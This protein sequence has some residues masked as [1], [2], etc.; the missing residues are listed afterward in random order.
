MW[1]HKHHAFTS[2]KF[3]F[4]FWPVLLWQRFLILDHVPTINSF[5]SNSAWTV[6]LL[7]ASFNFLLITCCIILYYFALLFSLLFVFVI[8]LYYIIRILYMTTTKPTNDVLRV[9]LLHQLCWYII[10]VTY[11]QI[12]L[13][14]MLIN[15]KQFSIQLSD[16]L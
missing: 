6:S 16:N 12:F 7:I 14:I 8:L 9:F 15:Q 2:N 3:L 11:T 10:V 4:K 1:Y 5:W 13:A